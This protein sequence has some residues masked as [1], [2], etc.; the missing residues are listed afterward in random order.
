M[1]QGLRL[2]WIRSI[3]ASAGVTLCVGLCGC[4]STDKPKAISTTSNPALSGTPA[5]YGSTPVTSKPTTAY[6][7]SGIGGMPGYPPPGSTGLSTS[8]STAGMQSPGSTG[9][10]GSPPLGSTGST[11]LPSAGYPSTGSSGMTGFPSTTGSTS[12]LGNGFLQ[13]GPASTT[14][15]STGTGS[16]V[17]QAGGIMPLSPAGRVGNQQIT[18]NF[19]ANG[20]GGVPALAGQTSA[21]STNSAIFN[22]PQTG[23]GD[24]GPVP[25]IAP[26]LVPPGK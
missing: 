22:P 25:P 4:D 1:P 9:V 26:P 20:G 14:M 8:G 11:G 7:T 10:M 6:P 3:F 17:Q 21:G 5:P 19:S 24:P 12:G 2:G 13:S 23:L 16:G 18:P 15:G